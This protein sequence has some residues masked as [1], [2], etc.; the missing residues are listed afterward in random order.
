MPPTFEREIAS[1]AGNNCPSAC[2]D[3]SKT[4]TS[5]VACRNTAGPDS[6][7]FYAL[8]SPPSSRLAD[9]L[10]SISNVFA[11]H[12]LSASN[13]TLGYPLRAATM[14]ASFSISKPGIRHGS[15]TPWSGLCRSLTIDIDS[16]ERSEAC[17]AGAVQPSSQLTA[18]RLQTSPSSPLMPKKPSTKTLSA[19]RQSK[20]FVDRARTAQ[21]PACSPLRS[22]SPAASLQ[23]AASQPLA[24]ERQNGGIVQLAAPSP[25]SRRVVASPR[26]C[27]LQQVPMRLIRL[28]DSSGTA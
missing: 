4:I 24:T 1:I 15:S 13:S 21:V 25:V 10:S 20:S 17:P 16:S 3:L 19:M 8:S 5:Q 27:W 26:R 23:P 2:S 22:P 18:G 11:P 14:T 12:Q 28:E 6:E 9:S 7:Q